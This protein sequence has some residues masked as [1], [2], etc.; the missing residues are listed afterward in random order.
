MPDRL[1]QR[2]AALAAEV[3]FPPT[4][5]LAATVRS[6]IAEGAPRP[7][8]RPVPARRSLALALAVLLVLAAVAGAV[9][10]VRDAVGDLLG[11][12]GATVERVP[13]MP[14]AP[15]SLDLGRPVTL[16]EAR[17]RVAFPVRVP[18]DTAL[19]E[20]D[21]VYLRGRR[22]F[23][24]VTLV[25]RPQPGLPRIATGPVGL[26][27]TEFRGDLDPDLVQKFI[28][29]GTGTRRVRVCPDDGFWIEGPHSFAY[30]DAQGEVRTED[31]RL[32]ANTLLWQRGPVLLRLESELPLRRALEIARTVE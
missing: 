17:E 10:A 30:R 3:E 15:G 27:L 13:Q 5:D 19:G 1:E 29:P 23:A 24:Q 11:L 8:R 18:A 7:P 16:A 21:A 2:L 32:A 26:L 22:P 6:R 20:P 4:P 25:H 31:R 28:G 14:E 9:P 12:D